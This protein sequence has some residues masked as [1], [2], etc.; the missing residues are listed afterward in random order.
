M[1]NLDSI[2]LRQSK[3]GLQSPYFHQM[4][5]SALHTPSLLIPGTEGERNYALQRPLSASQA[6]PEAQ[7][8]TPPSFKKELGMEESSSIEPATARIVVTKRTTP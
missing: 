3:P 5:L 1:G 7:P 8:L 4:A 2:A 6:M